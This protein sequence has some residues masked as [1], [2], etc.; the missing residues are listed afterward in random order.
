MSSMETKEG[1]RPATKL[2]FFAKM[3]ESA[4]M[5]LKE[6]VFETQ[7]LAGKALPCWTKLAVFAKMIESALMGLKEVVFETQ[8]LAGK[9][10]PCWSKRAVGVCPSLHH[11]LHCRPAYC[12]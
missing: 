2:A 11:E 6:V 1:G 10:L 12:R 7:V 9:A 4:L 5:G 3:I 8:V